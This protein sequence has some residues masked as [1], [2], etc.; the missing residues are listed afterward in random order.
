MN[1]A[2]QVNEKLD[3]ILFIRSEMQRMDHDLDDDQVLNNI[4]TGEK[5][6]KEEAFEIIE[7]LINE[8]KSELN[9]I[10]NN[11]LNIKNIFN[12]EFYINDLIQDKICADMEIN[13][14]LNN[15]QPNNIEL[16]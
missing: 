4:E 16:N 6:N 13:N 8:V 15:N 7:G 9:Q 3:Q 14:N 1:I 11:G 5:T 10:T 12:N 2:K